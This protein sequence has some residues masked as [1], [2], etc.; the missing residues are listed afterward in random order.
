MV[1]LIGKPGCGQCSNAKLN[2]SQRGINYEYKDLNL[3]PEEER[4]DYIN[5]AK[6]KNN[7]GLP[8]VF[9]NGENVSLQDIL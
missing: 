3:L 2:L 7:L 9:N 6:E 1:T 4:M 5:K 8:L